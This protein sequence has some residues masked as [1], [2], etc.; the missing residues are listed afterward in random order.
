MFWVQSG[1]VGAIAILGIYL[2]YRVIFPGRDDPGERE[3]ARRHA[4]NV[5]GIFTVAS[6]ALY[7]LAVWVLR[8]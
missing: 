3:S 2:R 1:I 4:L 6:L 8:W 7:L 5:L